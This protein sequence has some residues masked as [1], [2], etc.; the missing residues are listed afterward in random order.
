MSILSLAPES[1]VRYGDERF[2]ILHALD[3]F[4]SVVA[5]GL[6]SGRIRTLKVGDLLP[7]EASSTEDPARSPPDLLAIPDEDWKVAT[8]RL[9]VIDPFVGR[10]RVPRA[11]IEQRSAETGVAVTSIYR[12]MRAYTASGQLSG[13]LPVRRGPEPGGSLL[14]PAV[15]AILQDVIET[16]YLRSQRPT[17]QQTAVE[18]G[19]LCREQSLIP[20]HPN[21]V[22]N[23]IKRIEAEK[24]IARRY[25]AKHAENVQA[26]IRGHFPGADGPLFVVQADHTELDVILVD[27]EYRLPI[28]R[29]WL[30]LLIDVFSRMVLGFYLSLDRP[31]ASSVGLCLTRSILP[32]ERW[33]ARLGVEGEWPCWGLPHLLLVDNAKEFHSEMLERACEEYQITLQYRPKGK[34]RFGGHIERLLGTAGGEIHRLEGTTFSDPKERR[35]Y[36]SEGRACMALSE[37][38][39]WLARYFIGI[40]HAQIHSEIGQ[41]PLD[42]YRTGI[43]GTDEHAG[44]GYP[45]KV[46]DEERLKLDLMPFV[47]RTV[48]RG[49]IEVD[50]IEYWHDVLRSF[51]NAPDPE[52]PRQKRVFLFRRDPRDLSVIYFFN[53]TTERYI[54]I[55]YKN[56]TRPPIDLWQF[57]AARRRVRE[58]ARGKVDEEAIFR[59]YRENRKLEEQAAEQT[60]RARRERQRTKHHQQAERPQIEPAPSPPRDEPAT[61]PEDIHPFEE[62]DYLLPQRSRWA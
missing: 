18:I 56:R 35:E 46:V 29:P 26:P 30:T 25:G 45:R 11:E 57:R 15:E 47:L 16:F 9:E 49:G 60:K 20:P 31:N 19:R 52:H 4:T 40:Y 36:D 17:P 3:D 33:L 6:T 27:D 8:R 39:Q 23:R 62:I 10:H 61:P 12:W 58:T 21:T 55:P 34:P 43:V 13:L 2:V 1:V 37:L 53:P 7:A 14:S 44:T 32:K 48:Q 28:G 38:E 22:R 41:R 50:S 5:R 54:A 42:A 24:K 59:A 51:I